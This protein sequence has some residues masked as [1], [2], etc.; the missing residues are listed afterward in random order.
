MTDD[1]TP[2]PERRSRQTPVAETRDAEVPRPAETA[3]EPVPEAPV[4]IDEDG[5]PL[6]ASEPLA[7]PV[8]PQ[9]A[10]AAQMPQMPSP[11]AAAFEAARIVG[12]M[13][14]D[15]ESVPGAALA[16]AAA[17]GAAIEV[18][19]ARVAAGEPDRAPDDE[20]EDEIDPVALAAAAIARLRDRAR[21]DLAGLRV[22]YHRHD[23]L[24]LLAAFVIIVVAGRVHDALVTTATVLF[25]PSGPS[26]KYGLSFEHSKGW[27][28]SAGGPLPSPRIVH[29]IAP[30]PARPSARPYRVELT[31]TV[32]PTA[33]IEVMIDKKPAWSNIVT[34]LD[35][36]RRTRWGE[37]YTLDDSSVRS[38][39]DHQWLRT[40]YRFAHAV[41]KGD[42]PRVDRAVE[43]ATIDREQIYVITFF[44]TPAEIDR[45]EEVVA[46]TLRVATQTGLPLVPQT[47][48]LSARKYP[49]AV[50]RAFGA[51]V[52]VVVAD[53]VDGRL[54]ARGGGS[55]VIVGRDGSILTNY[56]VTHDKNGRL[57]D[58]F[59]IGR[60]SEQDKAPQLYCAGKPSR[61]KLQR[62][63]DLALIKCDLD[64][65]GRSWNPTSGGAIWA[66]LPQART[67]DLKMGQRVWVLGYPDVG[68]GGLTLSEGAALGWSG[69]D[70]AAGKDFLKTDAAIRHGNSG[71][72]VVDDAG[73]LVGIATA[74]RTRQTAAGDIIEVVQA[75]GRVRP[76][77]A[78]TDL[79]AIAAAGWTP[80]EGHTDVDLQPSAIEAP[81]EGVQIQ[82]RV[83]DVVNEAPVRDALVMVL[84]PGVTAGTIDVNRLDDQVIA[85]GRSNAQGDVLLKQPVPVP[86]TYTLMVV[87]RGYEPVIGEGELTLEAKTPAVFDPWG[88]ILLRAR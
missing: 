11:A 43:Y 20:A 24:V 62:E 84:R 72:P 80:R 78:A 16:A 3:K 77:A 34:G 2:K 25:D 9:P 55:G 13:V 42:V 17:A 22:Q 63:L 68:G 37:L 35:L 33:R 32:D 56:H 69:L 36:D 19:R 40:A 87:A 10:Q 73:R 39:E 88:K 49:N 44:G 7:G 61:G 67:G 53:I 29:E 26:G 30:W 71:G 8:E 38:V 50:A 15:I 83:L 81:A 28:T 51:T 45:I 6:D 52:M 47:G 12:E 76:I 57:H 79:L 82:S 5:W 75:G 1:T 74:V 14:G 60:F 59:V 58:V 46:P 21:T 86:G 85:Y 27:L 31:S 65:D 4:A 41:D 23:I 18:A 70:G 66:T 54:A 64:L 48:H